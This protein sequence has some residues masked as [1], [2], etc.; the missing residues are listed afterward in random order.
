LLKKDL[1]DVAAMPISKGIK[2][3]LLSAMCHLGYVMEP[4]IIEQR[5]KIDWAGKYNIKKCDENETNHYKN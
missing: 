3:N 1:K 2:Y 4:D 5:I